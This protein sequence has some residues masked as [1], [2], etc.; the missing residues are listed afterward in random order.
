MVRAMG[1]G[2]G[3]VGVVPWW[4]MRVGLRGV[5]KPFAP[6]T[7]VP[8]WALSPAIVQANDL[9]SVTDVTPPLSGMSR[10]RSDWV[11][12]NPAV[13]SSLIA[14]QKQVRPKPLISTY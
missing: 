13:L 9:I 11:G 12:T 5:W 8:L 6:S 14:L 4:S 10:H 7:L 2:K 1:Q 3:Q